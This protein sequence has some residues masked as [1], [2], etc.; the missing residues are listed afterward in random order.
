MEAKTVIRKSIFFLSFV[1]T[2]NIFLCH[3]QHKKISYLLI[4]STDQN[5][6]LLE[7]GE[8]YEK[9]LQGDQIVFIIGDMSLGITDKFIV[10][11][12]NHELK[13][14]YPTTN[15]CFE[16]LNI[17]QLKSIYRREIDSL[18]EK[19]NWHD[20]FKKVG[21]V[22]IVEQNNLDSLLVYKAVWKTYTGVLE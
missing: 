15:N 19:S 12:K 2:L 21:D 22:N 13:T 5:K 17:K 1:L 4:E 3:G 8:Y 9:L 7:T 20:A 16:V 14:F 11:K 10:S 18:L 6:G